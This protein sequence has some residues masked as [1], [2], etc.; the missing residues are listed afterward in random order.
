M[1]QNLHNNEKNK[2]GIPYSNSPAI[3]IEKKYDSCHFQNIIHVDIVY[4]ICI[5]V[6]H[7][8]GNKIGIKKY[9]KYRYD[10]RKKVSHD[11]TRLG[12][13]IY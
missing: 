6:Y 5:Y 8:H 7:H 4:R 3:R 1:I 13:Y 9:G 11:E 2:K 12:L 10:N